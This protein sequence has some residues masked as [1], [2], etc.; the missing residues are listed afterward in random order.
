MENNYITKCCTWH[1]YQNLHSLALISLYNWANKHENENETNKLLPNKN[2]TKSNI[3]NFIVC[4]GTHL[5]CEG[6]KKKQRKKKRNSFMKFSFFSA[7]NYRIM[8]LF[9][10]IHSDLCFALY[11]RA[12]CTL[13]FSLA[14]NWNEKYIQWNKTKKLLHHRLEMFVYLCFQCEHKK[15]TKK[16]TRKKKKKKQTTVRPSDYLIHFR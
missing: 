14:W 12:Y 15:E 5:K 13:Q 6:K 3:N 11:L 8:L 2:E 10:F 16:K 4:N 9:I 1:K 7:N